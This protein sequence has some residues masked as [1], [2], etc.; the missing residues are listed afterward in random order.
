LTEHTTNESKRGEVIRVAPEVHATLLHLQ[1][2]RK[3]AGNP[4]FAFGEIV[5]DGLDALTQPQMADR[6]D[7]KTDAVPVAK[8]NTAAA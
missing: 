8:A 3:I 2:Q 4:R 5:R 6:I 7:L 1:F